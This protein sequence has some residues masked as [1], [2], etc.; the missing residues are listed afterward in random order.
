MSEI[1]LFSP[2]GQTLKV[3]VQSKTH[4]AS[5]GTDAAGNP[6]HELRVVWR[7]DRLDDIPSGSDTRLYEIS[8]TQRV[9]IEGKDA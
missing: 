9:V 6:Y 3:Q 5:A 4:E 7:T 8:P 2:E 1:R